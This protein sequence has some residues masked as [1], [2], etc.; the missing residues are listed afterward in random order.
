MP[1]GRANSRRRRQ[2]GNTRELKRILLITMTTA[3]KATRPG[4]ANTS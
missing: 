3:M 2:R 4:V 1:D